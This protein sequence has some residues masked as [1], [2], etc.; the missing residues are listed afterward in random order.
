MHYLYVSMLSSI[1]IAANSSNQISP[2]R[3]ACFI[4]PFERDPKFI[5]R[6]ELITEIDRRFEV[7]KR[8]ALAGIGG[9]GSVCLLV[10]PEMSLTWPTGSHRLR[11]NTAIGS[12]IKTLRVTS[13]G[14]MPAL[15]PG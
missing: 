5:G 15:C 4:V 6:E 1:S 9:V 11:L 13:S 14:Y 8:V 3:T 12:A 2:P 7:Q 10:R